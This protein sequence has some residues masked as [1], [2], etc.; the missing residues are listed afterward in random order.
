[1]C[2]MATTVLIVLDGGFRFAGGSDPASDADVDFTYSTLVAALENAGMAVTRAH[3]QVDSTA[4]PGWTMFQFHAPP[5]GHSLLEFDAIWLIGL[6]G[7]NVQLPSSIASGA[8][9]LDELELKAIARYMDAGGG[10]FATGDHD[11]IGADMCGHIPRVRAMRAWFGEGDTVAN[12]PAN[13]PR[14]NPRSGAVRA[15]TTRRNPAGQYDA[16]SNPD[17]A[18][19]H[20]WFENQ[21]DSVPQT[22]VPAT[23]PAHPILRR[24]G[25]DIVV[26]PDHMHEGKC[27]GEVAGYH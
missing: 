15:D 18:T 16:A 26:Y 1:M 11:S 19:D 12:I 20:V 3:R 9:A 13:L 7:R 6:Q 22:I 25:H 23:S 5:A 27:L 24:N 2:A 17:G 21:S 4:T 10:I 8:F 14:N